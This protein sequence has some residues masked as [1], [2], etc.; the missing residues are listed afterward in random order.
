MESLLSDPL[1]LLP[2]SYPANPLP[3]PLRRDPVAD[4]PRSPEP[5]FARNAGASRERLSL[6]PAV[7]PEDPIQ[8]KLA[9]GGPPVLGCLGPGGSAG[10]GRPVDLEDSSP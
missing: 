8:V 5:L 6:T 3:E 10:T 4:G 1:A 7:G 2:G 9:R